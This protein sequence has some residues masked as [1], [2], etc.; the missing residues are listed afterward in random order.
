[1]A[2]AVDKYLRMSE[3]VCHTELFLLTQCLDTLRPPGHEPHWHTD[4][5]PKRE[6]TELD[7]TIYN[8]FIVLM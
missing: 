6:G 4:S 1:M 2:L 7:Y 8:S 3:W 5:F